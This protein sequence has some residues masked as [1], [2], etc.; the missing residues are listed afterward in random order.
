[1]QLACALQVARSGSHSVL[2]PDALPFGIF[3]PAVAGVRLFIP[4]S[5]PACLHP[6]FLAPGPGRPAAPGAQSPAPP[7]GGSSSSLFART[8]GGAGRGSRSGARAGSRGAAAG[9]GAMSGAGA[10]AGRGAAP[11]LAQGAGAGRGGVLAWE[12]GSSLGLG[13]AG[14]GS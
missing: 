8:A 10:E 7:P 9:Q 5:L 13:A 12:R 3:L 2:Q 6:F 1:M 4:P 14:S 11:G